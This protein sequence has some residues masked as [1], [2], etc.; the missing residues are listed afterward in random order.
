MVKGTAKL[1]VLVFLSL[2]LALAQN[3][4]ANLN[5]RQ[6]P[7]PNAAQASPK[8]DNEPYLFA[9][10][11]RGATWTGQKSPELTRLQEGHMANINRMANLGKLIAAG[12]MGDDG[13][14]RGIFVFRGVS[15]EEA[16]QLCGEDPMLKSGHL[17]IEVYEWWGSKGI[18][19]KYAEEAK[20]TSPDKIPMVKI[21]LG[22]FTIGDNQA[23]ATTSETQQL[24]LGHLW[25]LRKLMDAGKIVAAGPVSN[26]SD[27]RGIMVLQTETLQEA[28]AIANQ[29]PMVKAGRLKVE[30]H[31]W[32]VSK[33]VMP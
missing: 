10:L 8:F 17:K 2:S 23:T 16:K 5:N 12:P 11:S 29:D 14:L 30:L 9:T 3:N 26:N 25:H 13:N 21:F 20:K 28:R 4:S 6:N 27:I 22:L 24:Q 15:L 1:L 33:G 7:Q 19:V 18:G 31:P 32:W